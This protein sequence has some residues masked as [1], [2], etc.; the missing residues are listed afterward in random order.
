MSDIRESFPI[1]ED[2][3]GVG[4]AVSK[5]SEG[6]VALGKVSLPAFAYKDSAGNLILPQLDAQGRL[7][8]NTETQGTRL[9][10]P[11]LTKTGVT[12]NTAA[13]KTIVALPLTANKSY[14]DIKAR[15]AC[16]RAAVFQLVYSDSASQVVLSDGVL[17]AGQYNSSLGFE[18]G[19]SFTVPASGTSP[20][21]L[22]L[23]ANYEVASDLHASLVCVQF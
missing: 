11:S 10:A 13:L 22:V 14:G 5:S 15:I 7:P 20:Q 1:L 9:R 17:D 6:D 21:F 23:G 18:G 4:F 2:A 3:T 12:G 19:D 16:R 8:V